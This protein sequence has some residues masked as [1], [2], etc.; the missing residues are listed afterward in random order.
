MENRRKAFACRIYFLITLFYVIIFGEIELEE[1]N[2]RRWLKM[3][4]PSQQ[5]DDALEAVLLDSLLPNRRWWRIPR[6]RVWSQMVLNEELLE[7][8][9]FES[10]FRMTRNSF[11]QLPALLG[12]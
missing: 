5:L 6:C 4:S 10:T 7:E 3:F 11:N 12:I 2:R 9:E 8:E 1:V